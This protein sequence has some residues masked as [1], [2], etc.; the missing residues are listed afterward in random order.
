MEKR[1]ER[2]GK[3]FVCTSDVNCWCSTTFVAPK[4]LIY[5]SEFYEDC[6]CKSCIVEISMSILPQ[7]S[8]K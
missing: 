2:C 6:I 1:C 5:I 3:V 7:V 8:F 4:V